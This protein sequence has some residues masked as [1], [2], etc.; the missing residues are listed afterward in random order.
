MNGIRGTA[1][2][3]LPRGGS[4]DVLRG[5]ILVRR[6]G[7]TPGPPRAHEAVAAHL[8]RRHGHRDLRPRRVHQHLL[9]RL[10][11]PTPSSSSRST[12]TTWRPGRGDRDEHLRGQP[13]RLKPYG[14]A[15]KTERSTGRGPA[16]AGSR[17]EEVFVAGSWACTESRSGCPT[18]SRPRWRPPSA[19][20][21]RLS[22]RGVDCSSWRP[23]PT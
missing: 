7:V 11:S 18:R 15:E 2:D 9:R 21:W 17:G 12:G 5:E 16:G 3:D 23:S 1:F 20:R 10:C 13:D 19:R 22:R 6:A 4:A 8:R 14:L